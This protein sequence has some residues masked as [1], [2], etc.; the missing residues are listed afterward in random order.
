MKKIRIAF[1]KYCGLSSGGT[2]KF[3][4]TIAANL[5]KSKY[6]VDF[7]YTE[8]VPFIGSAHKHNGTD[9]VRKQY[10]IRNGVNLI[11]V[12]LDAVD[13]TRHTHPWV[14]TNL[15]DV[16]CEENY[17]IIQTGR[18]GYPEYPFTKIRKTPIVDSLHLSAGVDNQYNI[19]RVMHITEWSRKI[20]EKKGGDALRSVVVSH[21]ME[22]M[23]VDA[24]PLRK[25]LH[26]PENRIIC[27]FHQRNSDAIFSHY[28]L[29]AYAK[30]ETKDT[31]FILLGGSE[32]Y[33]RQA[34]E[35]GIQNISF[36]DYTADQQI[37][38]NFLSTLDIYV[39]GRADG[40]VN[41]TA[42]AEAMYFGLP[43]LSHISH[44]N[45]GHIECIG[46]AGY[47]AETISDYTDYLAK[48][49][50]DAPYRKMIAMNSKK[51]FAV[52][53]ELHTQIAHIESIY[54]D[55]ISNPFPHKIR[56]YIAQFRLRRFMVYI[57]TKIITMIWTSILR[58]LG[59][60][61]FLL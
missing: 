34:R 54:N 2:E 47:V 60:R 29:E 52:K 46:N 25:E 9:D 11:E 14:N 17:D 48:L 4:Q 26:I 5:N 12:S 56:R 38:Y 15:F 19:S 43:I 32:K 24:I 35:I 42:M 41:S 6:E 16:F 58:R 57:P 7:Y 3:L 1:I 13:L 53:Y 33:R 39:H 20:W 50:N 61:K 18:G 8:S 59:I 45:N 40:E 55:V 44:I 23:P 49:L 10:L 28:P 37:I 21:P 31:H 36:L 51:R 27:G 22:I 30:L